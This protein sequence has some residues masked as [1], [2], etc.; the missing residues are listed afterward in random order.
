MHVAAAVANIG[1]EFQKREMML[2]V[3]DQVWKEDQKR[4]Q[5]TQPDPRSPEKLAVRR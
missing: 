3:P 4:N 5:A 1:L 2:I